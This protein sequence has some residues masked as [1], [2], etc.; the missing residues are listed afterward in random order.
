MDTNI[1]GLGK[2]TGE[3]TNIWPGY[4]KQDSMCEVTNH[5]QGEHLLKN[6]NK[7]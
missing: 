4:A 7:P 3:L 5:M 6:E 2:V 1:S